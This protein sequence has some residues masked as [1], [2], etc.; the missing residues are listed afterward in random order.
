M[1][2]LL[3]EPPC[4]NPSMKLGSFEREGILGKIPVGAYVRCST[5]MQDH[6]IEDQSKAILRYAEVN[7]FEVTEWFKDEGTSGR[8]SWR[9][10]FQRLVRLVEAHR[11]PFSTLLVYD[12]SRWGRF[13]D[14]DEAAFWEFYLKRNGIS[15]VYTN[16]SF[17]DDGSFEGSI[18]KTLS[19]LEAKKRSEDQ[20]RIVTERSRMNAE[21]GYS[22][23][24]S[25]P[26][27]YKRLLVDEKGLPIRVLEPGEHKVEKKQRVAFTLGDP[28]EVAI[29]KRIFELYANRRYGERRI[30]ELLNKESIPSP[31]G[32]YWS[33]GTLHAVLCRPAYYGARVYYRQNQKRFRERK[34]GPYWYPREEWV[35][36]EN[37]H[38][39]IISKA[40]FEK[41]QEIKR[42][43]TLH[44]GGGRGYQST[45][46]LTKLIRCLRCGHHYQG[47]CLIGSGGRRYHYYEDGGWMMKGSSVCTRFRIPRDGKPYRRRTV[48]GIE[49]FVLDH[50]RGKIRRTDI[51]DRMKSK[52]KE[53]LARFEDEVPDRLKE[54]DKTIR[55]TDAKIDHLLDAI[56]V[57]GLTESLRGRLGQRHSEKE[58]LLKE[59]EGLIERRKQKPDV[60]AVVADIISYLADF[61]SVLECGTPGE[62]K[63]VV[64]SFVQR[65][66]VDPLEKKAICYFYKLPKI[67]SEVC[68]SPVPE[69]GVEPT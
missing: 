63:A 36:K 32:G 69:V 50:I 29:V 55:A 1:A 51:R 22:S 10:E 68:V 64:R 58:K 52:L 43:R 27:G 37:A 34:S 23:G 21:R 38:P 45:Y 8:F 9:P 2:K 24:G 20:S 46:L 67:E 44:R 19:R 26:F 65:I 28:Q 13:E 35:I 30:V 40:I 53:K 14:L 33:L 61:E 42:E 59:R 16:E 48:I 41:A 66:E 39:A 3:F 47:T 62:R 11:V 17:K 56:E 25:A 18:L 57:S 6:S 49:D 7:G 31:G 4:P 12:V 60:D 54:I 5:D 15:V